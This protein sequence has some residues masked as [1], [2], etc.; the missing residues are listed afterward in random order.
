[1][2]PA[3]A[4]AAIVA[5]GGWHGLWLLAGRADGVGMATTLALLAA[6]G[7]AL[8]RA[9]HAVRADALA[10]CLLAIGVAGWTGIALVEIGVTVTALLWCAL[11]RLR[12]PVLALALLAVPILPTLDVLLAWPLR[13]VSALLTLGMLRMNGIGVGLEGVALEWHGQQLLF[14]GPCSGVRMLWAMLVLASLAAA[15]RGLPPLRF[16]L[17]LAGAVVV[18]IIGNAVRAASL[19]YVESGFV[20][21]LQGP[22]AH[23]AVGLAAFALVAGG[24]VALV[25]R[26]GLGR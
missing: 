17:L 5:L 16:A 21:M 18:A 10:A 15:I 1:M 19:F 23:E 24:A 14:D 9:R 13:R 2:I 6:L 8:V 7:W 3:R 4:A 20:P 22:I 11:P 25:S 12:W 26:R